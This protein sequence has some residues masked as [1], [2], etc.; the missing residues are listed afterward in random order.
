MV[1]LMAGLLLVVQ[2]PMAFLV[3]RLS[4]QAALNR[5][6]LAPAAS[7]GSPS[8]QERLL[9]IYQTGLIIRLALVEGVAMLGAIAYLIEGRLAAIAVSAIAL[10]IMVAFFPT[11]GSVAS[12]LRTRSTQMQNA[13]LRKG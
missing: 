11:E 1:T 4:E 9:N 2:T 3:P 12:W 13:R 7:P 6:A 5:L 10:L 8:D